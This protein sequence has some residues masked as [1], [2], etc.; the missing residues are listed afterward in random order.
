MRQNLSIPTPDG[1]ARA[2]AFT[3]STGKGPWPAV[4]MF[5]DGVAIRPALFEMAE[6]LASNGYYVLLPDMFWRAGPYEPIDVKKVFTLPDEERRKLYGLLMGSTSPEKAMRDTGAFLDW[7]AQQP[8]AKAGKIG[9]TGYCMGGGFALHAAGTYPERIAA[10]A[11][12]HPGNLATDAANSPHLLA[13]QIEAAVLVAGGDQDQS[14]DE[15]QKDRLA[16]AFENAGV[17]ATVSIWQG[18]RHGWVPADTPVHNPDGAER[19]WRELI[20]LYDRTLK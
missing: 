6:R 13:P 5:M 11:C 4:L 17:E 8:Q 3:P 1:D 7:L 16:A 2:F 18:C 9:V 15:A 12:F 10:A 19:H 20:A 14:F